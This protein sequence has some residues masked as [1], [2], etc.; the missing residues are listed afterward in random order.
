[1]SKSD[2][3][4]CRF[5]GCKHPTR[6][7]DIGTEPY[8]KV[9]TMYYHED[10]FQLKKSNEWKDSQ[11]RKDLAEFR[12]IWFNRIS[13]TVNYPQLMWILND[14]IARGVSSDYLLFTLKYILNN[15]MNLNYPNGFKY[16]VDR[17]D[18]KKA[19]DKHLIQKRIVEQ[20]KNPVKTDVQDNAPKFSVKTK[21]KGF[22]TIL[23]K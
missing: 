12:E 16:Y 8:T 4:K 18:I 22:Q 13:R 7:I 5:V 14:Y 20:A 3:K 6:E 1:M 17:E 9:G 19:Y 11:T 15:N 10:C 23:G 21:P 2:I